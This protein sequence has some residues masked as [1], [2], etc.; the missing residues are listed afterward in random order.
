[1]ERLYDD[2]AA[3]RP[4]CLTVWPHTDLSKQKKTN[5]CHCPGKSDLVGKNSCTTKLPNM[6]HTHGKL[7]PLDFINKQNERERQVFL[8][9]PNIPLSKNL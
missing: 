1:M 3:L 2:R 5:F 9:K 4:E 6:T 7:A 8:P